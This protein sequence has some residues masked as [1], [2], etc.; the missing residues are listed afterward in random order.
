MPDYKEYQRLY[1][2]KI[3]ELIQLEYLEY[4]KRT[5]PQ[6]EK[7]KT[8]LVFRNERARELLAGESEEV[9]KVVET[10][11]LRNSEEHEALQKGKNKELSWVLLSDLNYSFFLKKKTTVRSS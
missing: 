8:A 11:R 2:Y 5:L 1:W 7:H 4:L 10:S 6:N 3:A 9:K